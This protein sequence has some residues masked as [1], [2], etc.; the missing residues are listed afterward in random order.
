MCKEQILP[1]STGEADDA[2]MAYN[3]RMIL[4]SDKE[5]QVPIEKPESEPGGNMPMWPDNIYKLGGVEV[6]GK[7][8]STQSVTGLRSLIPGHGDG[9]SFLVVVQMEG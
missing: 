8:I 2:V 5:N 9:H 3:Y 1:K 7:E 6:K 4:T